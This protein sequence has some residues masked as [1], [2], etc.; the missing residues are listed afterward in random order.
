M[1]MHDNIFLLLKTVN[2]SFISDMC[3]KHTVEIYE[4]HSFTK[5]TLHFF[6]GT[7]SST[8]CK[9]GKSSCKIVIKSTSVLGEGG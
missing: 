3:D 8:M 1:K 5:I 9:V 2:K 6:F 4:Y 7:M